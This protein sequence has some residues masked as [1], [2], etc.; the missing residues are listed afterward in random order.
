MAAFG[1]TEFEFQ[2]FGRTVQVPDADIA[3]VMYYLDCVC[4]VI[5]YNDNNIRRYRNY[6]NWRNM[7]DEE[8]RFI[9]LLALALS[10]DELEDKVF[11]NAPALCPDSSNQFYEIGQV[12]RQIMVVQSI[13]I[14]GQSRQVKK[15]MAYKQVWMRANYYEPMQ[16]LAFRF[17]PAGQRQE[18]LMR[19]AA[20]T[21]S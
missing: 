10:P 4:T 3:K 13:I 14:G 18:A 7:S 21:I 9:F 19:S 17:S 6:S 8:D 20:C 15:I 16:R 5:E 12:R 1:S 11:F 2:R